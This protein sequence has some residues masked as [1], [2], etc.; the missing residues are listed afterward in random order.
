MVIVSPLYVTDLTKVA[1]GDA[2][3][4]LEARITVRIPRLMKAIVGLY[5]LFIPLPS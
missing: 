4:E 2:K 5:K 3:A 1:G